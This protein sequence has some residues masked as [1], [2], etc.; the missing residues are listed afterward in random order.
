MNDI[1]LIDKI[2]FIKNYI[3]SSYESP[4]LTSEVISIL[5]Q[6]DVARTNN[7]NGIFVNLS[8]VKQ[9]IIEQLFEL[10]QTNLNSK[11]INTF[12]PKNNVKKEKKVEED[13]FIYK[14]DKLSLTPLDKFIIELS[15]TD[16]AL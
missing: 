3:S 2:K 13:L 9:A 4:E 12:L 5:N 6:C 8:L 1:E 15:S 10:C 16:L 7:K 11:E 14:P